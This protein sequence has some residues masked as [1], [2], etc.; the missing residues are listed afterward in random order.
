MKFSSCFV[1]KLLIVF[2]LIFIVAGCAKNTAEPDKIIPPEGMVYVQGGGYNMGDHH[3]EGFYFESPCRSVTLDDF[4]IG[5]KEVTQLEYE[6]I[7]GN[8]PSNT[9]HS[10]GTGDNYPVFYISWFDAVTYC[11]LRS[12]QEGLDPC[13][14]LIDWTCN[15]EAK[16]YRLPTEAE[17]E[18]AAR[19]GI[20]W[21][22]DLN[23]SG[24]HLDSELSDFAWYVNP[25]ITGCNPVG[26]KQPN[27][28]GIYD[29]S[30]NLHEWCHDWFG[31][32]YYP[33]IPSH[34]P[35]GVESGES[36]VKRGGAYTTTSLYCRVSSR[37]YN[38]PS[39]KLRSTGFRVVRPVAD[40]SG[41]DKRT[42]MNLE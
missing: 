9:P 12:E 20:N 23:Y 2:N 32:H 39:S 28:L 33:S 36:R 5:K 26:T 18:Y 7:V 4:F 29:M 15:F 38:N 42:C 22:D 3:N 17:W 35:A 30:G 27:Q 19:G 25:F 41:E 21:V 13:Y 40:G 16:G 11:N 1:L 34:N 6:T 14:N 24:C 10:Y 31:W 37:E 8:N